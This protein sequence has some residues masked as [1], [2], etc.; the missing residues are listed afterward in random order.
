LTAKNQAKIHHTEQHA[1]DYQ[2]QHKNARKKK[3]ST[4]ISPTRLQLIFAHMH[5]QGN[6]TGVNNLI[7]KERQ[8]AFSLQ[9]NHMSYLAKI[10]QTAQG[11][12]EKKSVLFIE[13]LLVNYQVH[14]KIETDNTGA[15]IDGSI[16]LLDKDGRIRGTVTVQVKTVNKTDEG[17]FRFPCPTSL[18]A[19]AEVNSVVVL[20]LAVDHSN[21]VV[22]WKHISRQLL[23]DNRDKEQQETITLHFT[24]TERLSQD[25]VEETLKHWKLLSQNSVNTLV[26]A[27][28]IS[29]E[30]EELRELLINSQNSH[31]DLDL[32]DI[33]KIQLFSDT[34]NNLYD[35]DLLFFKKHIF[36]DYWKTG[37]AIFK[38]EDHEL[39][40]SLFPIQYGENSLLIKQ[41]PLSTLK[42]CR[43]PYVSMNCEK[44]CIKDNPVL[45]AVEFIEKQ[46]SSFI[47]KQNIIPDYDALL[48]E[49]VRDICWQHPEL[50]TIKEHFD[51]IERIIQNMEKRYPGISNLSPNTIYGNK[52][53]NIGNLYNTILLLKQR[54]YT[55]IPSVYPEHGNYGHTD[56]VSDSFSVET[57]F[58]KLQSVASIAHSALY[59]F[60]SENIPLT[61]NV[62]S[63]ANLIIYDLD[64]SPR[65]NSHGLPLL[66]AY[67][68]EDQI[69]KSKFTIEC[70]FHND[71]HIA[72]ENNVKTIYDLWKID[73]INHNG[74]SYKLIK[75]GGCDIN[76]Y[77]FG[78]FNIIS[79]FN[80]LLLNHLNGYFKMI[81]R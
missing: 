76:K 46:L 60:I 80:E 50:K 33:C 44:N 30:N 63:D 3:L 14:S 19:Y 56:F 27:P 38:Y 71:L 64:Y 16:E 15:N 74:G 28:R 11:I 24:E 29:K 70:Y 58:K 45:F 79:V 59:R 77:I 31:F 66:N 57:A 81:K 20:L 48:I 8:K 32:E 43:D 18:F 5:A 78:H 37:L 54:G 75:T 40:H 65:N 12:K 7:W 23:E 22:L 6:K 67:Y 4:A 41:L 53:L 9:K 68:Y 39:I 55:K 13:S 69:D 72:D 25:N 42:D 61:Q 49:Y 10:S 1:F 52:N 73:N 34:F 26:N 51:D 2:K 35:K 47:E 62:T 17:K 36:H 21:E